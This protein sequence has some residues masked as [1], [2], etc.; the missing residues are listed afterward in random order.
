[1]VR[2][3][4]L[5][6]QE[7]HKSISYK[8]ARPNRKPLNPVS[9]TYLFQSAWSTSAGVEEEGAEEWKTRGQSE[10]RVFLSQYVLRTDSFLL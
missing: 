10:R 7:Q 1:M 4:V 8:K 2:L 3:S 5:T 9:Q 6:Q